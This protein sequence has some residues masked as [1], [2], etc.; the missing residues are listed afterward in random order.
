[1]VVALSGVSPA[2]AAVFTVTTNA[3][4]G[5]GSLRAALDG[6]AASNGPDTINVNAG[7]GTIV[8]ES[9]LTY[10]GAGTDGVTTINGNGMVIDANGQVSGIV[11]DDGEGVTI[12]GFT[13]FGVGGKSDT[14]AA[15][16]VSQGGDVSVGDCTIRNNAVDSFEGD[17]SGGVLSEGGALNI[18]NCEIFGNTATTDDGDAGGGALSEG[19]PVQVLRSTI[20]ANSAESP[21]GNVAG[22]VSSEGGNITMRDPVLF[23]NFGS[24]VE[25]DAAGG[26][27]LEGGAVTING[28]ELA[29]NI[30]ENSDPGGFAAGGA[31]LDG[32]VTIGTTSFTA[33]LASGEAADV[34]NHLFTDD[35]D[36]QL[37]ETT[38]SDDADIC[39]EE[40]PPEE[41]E[42]P[43]AAQPAAQTP[44]FT[45]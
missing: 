44:Q 4:A 1:L 19:G 22:G 13:I 3:D 30:A 16:V 17:V 23:G 2:S 40:P 43:P 6:A 15:P 45:G 27:L 36:P 28:G 21:N 41:P 35:P 32:E 10:G 8:L 12:V 14:D 9:P 29:C 31:G 33:N 38:F 24:A 20:E 37:T 26:V 39:E 7:I 11:D 5:A 25:G 34:E 18:D 42:E